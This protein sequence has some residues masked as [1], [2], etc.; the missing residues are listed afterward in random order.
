MKTALPFPFRSTIAPV[1]PVCTSVSCFV[2][3]FERACC[4]VNEAELDSVSSTILI[5]F[6][7]TR[8]E[9]R[10]ARERADAREESQDEG[11]ERK[12]KD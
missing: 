6:D 2:V 10:E 3:D 12:E 1:E 5:R 4:P 8:E 7:R 9:R 11:K